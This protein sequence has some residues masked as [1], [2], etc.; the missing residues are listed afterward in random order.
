MLPDDLTTNQSMAACPVP[1]EQLPLNEYEDLRESWFFRWA[2]LETP[3]YVA[4]ILWVW[5]WSLAIAA[6]V[7]AASFPTA[8]YPAKFLLTST[9]G[10]I[11]FVVLLLIRLYLG[12]SYVAS[13]LMDSNVVYEESGWYDGQI[14]VKPMEVL[15]RDRL[16]V[17][18]QIQP[19]LKRMQ[20]TFGVLI[21]ILLSGAILWNLFLH[22]EI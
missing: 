9:A 20:Q 1:S 18:Y 2:T 17:T 4:K 8:K 10:A 22:S 19:F 11:A 6:P 16:V 14:W 12:W 13:R 5:I 15:T 3:R 21:I 7:A